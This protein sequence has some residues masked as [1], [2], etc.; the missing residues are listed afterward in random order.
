MSARLFYADLSEFVKEQLVS[1]FQDERMEGPDSPFK[2]H[3]KSL[4]PRVLCRVQSSLGT[5]QNLFAGNV[6]V[7]IEPYSQPVHAKQAL[8]R[9]HRRG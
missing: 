8:K 1:G 7:F 2:V 4:R 3:N 6:C 9:L 5:G